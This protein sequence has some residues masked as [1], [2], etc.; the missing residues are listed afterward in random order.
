M[1]L[2]DQAVDALKI[3]DKRDRKTGIKAVLKDYYI[4]CLNLHRLG[5]SSSIIIRSRAFA[6]S[7][8]IEN[9]HSIQMYSK[10]MQITK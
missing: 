3:N 9:D 8:D 4:P 6:H 7:M 2:P 1:Y 10:L 5:K